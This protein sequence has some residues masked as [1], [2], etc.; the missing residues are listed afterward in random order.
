MKTAAESVAAAKE[1]NKREKRKE[2]R[3]CVCLFGAE[4][5]IQDRRR[6]VLKKNA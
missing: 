2:K 6:K 3:V 1:T 4:G 5:K